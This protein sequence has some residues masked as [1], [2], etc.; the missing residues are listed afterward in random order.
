MAASVHLMNAA[1]HE[2]GPT[3]VQGSLAVTTTRCD[4]GAKLRTP[5]TT[6]WP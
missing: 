2:L 3:R 4:G 1:D 5:T 6:A